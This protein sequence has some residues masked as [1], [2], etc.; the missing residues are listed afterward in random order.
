MKE[1]IIQLALNS[2]IKD[3]ALNEVLSEICDNNHSSCASECPVYHLNGN[4]IP[5]SNT[6]D[7]CDVFQSAPKMLAFI[8]KHTKLTFTKI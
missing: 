4:K 7:E 1:T 3:K 6:N 8:R 5:E 2:N